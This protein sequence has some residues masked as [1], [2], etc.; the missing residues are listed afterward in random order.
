VIDL[1]NRTT[2]GTKVIVLPA[3]RRA[4]S[5]STVTPAAKRTLY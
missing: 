3:E 2:I 5:P 1:Y 4:E